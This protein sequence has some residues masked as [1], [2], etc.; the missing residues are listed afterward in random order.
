[1]EADGP[2]AETGDPYRSVEEMDE[3]AGTADHRNRD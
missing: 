3:A 2:V 1:V